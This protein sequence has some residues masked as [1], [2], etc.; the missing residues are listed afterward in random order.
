MQSAANPEKWASC[1]HKQ[2]ELPFAARARKGSSLLYQKERVGCF[3]LPRLH[4]RSAEDDACMEI[5]ESSLPGFA[6]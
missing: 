5:V 1:F 2:Q 4:A 6:F 3:A